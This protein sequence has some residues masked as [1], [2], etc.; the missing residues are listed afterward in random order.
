MS[1]PRGN[2]LGRSEG[3]RSEGRSRP[4]LLHRHI[5]AHAAGSK[6]RRPVCVGYRRKVVPH[7]QFAS[8]SRDEKPDHRM[9]ADFLMLGVEGDHSSRELH[10]PD[11]AVCCERPAAQEQRDARRYEAAPG[12][13]RSPGDGPRRHEEPVMLPGRRHGFLPRSSAGELRRI[14]DCERPFDLPAGGPDLRLTRPT[15]WAGTVVRTRSAPRFATASTA[16]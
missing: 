11:F 8:A 3:P 9:L 12:T 5:G 2:A 15:S 16:S 7:Q 1:D 10:P 6:E 4:S 14:A 13:R